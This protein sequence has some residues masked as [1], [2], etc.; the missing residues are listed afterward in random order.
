[1]RPNLQLISC[2]FAILFFGCSSDDGGN[3]GGGGGGGGLIPSATYRVTFSPDFTDQTHPTDY[4]ANPQFISM[5][6]M[7]HNNTRDLFSLGFAG[8]DGF[9]TYATTGDLSG[10]INEHSSGDDDNPTVI[11]TGLNI[12]PTGEDSVTFT[13]G[14]ETTLISFVARLDPSPDWVVGV[15]AFNLVN[16]DNSLVET[17]GA[18]LFPIDAGADGGTTYEAAD[19]PENG[20]VQS[21]SG[22]PFENGGFIAKLG[23]FTIERIGQ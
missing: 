19:M 22:P 6:V 15:D 12:G 5:F 23:D 1:M 17:G 20:P 4:P 14:P 11:A 3:T 2:L 9:K 13:I 7:A 18:P 8:S 16:P 21:Y 10:L